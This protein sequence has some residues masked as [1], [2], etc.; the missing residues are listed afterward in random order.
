MNY[1][2]WRSFFTKKAI[3]WLNC[4]VAYAPFHLFPPDSNRFPF[5]SP[6]QMT[7]WPNS[8]PLL[9]FDKSNHSPK[10]RIFPYIDLFF[11]HAIR[12]TPHLPQSKRPIDDDKRSTGEAN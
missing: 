11:F 12:G 8:F 10:G 2:N 5:F 9:F 3:C 6:F 4:N 1:A 7:F